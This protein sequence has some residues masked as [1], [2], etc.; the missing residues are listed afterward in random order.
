MKKILSI[1]GGGIKGVFP[2]SFLATL[3]EGLAHPIGE[4]FD[5]LVGTS[6][7]GIIALSLGLGKTAEQTVGSYRSLGAEV[8]GGSSFWRWIR[9]WSQAKYSSD[10]LKSNLIT[11]FGDQCLGHSKQRLL[12]PSLSLETGDVYIF[13][14]AHHR[15]Y[16]RDYKE[17][18]V[19]V[20]LATCAAPTFFPTFAHMSGMS[21]IDGGV[22]ANNPIN[23]A[24]TE[25]I[26]NLGWS[27][28]EIEVLSIG[29][30]QEALSIE[31]ARRQSKGLGYWGLKMTDLALHAQSSGSLG[32]AM[33]LLNNHSIYRFNPVVR[34]GKYQLDGVQ[35]MDFLQGLGVEEARKAVPALRH[36]FEETAEPYTPHYQLS[37][38][39]KQ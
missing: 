7:G 32:V 9:Q 26:G 15:R 5:L 21:L 8:F 12:I 34:G 17:T 10:A 31:S 24:V 3:E 29:C 4:Y 1:D 33:T 16:T 30:T 25:A 38:T 14:T 27:P 23:L 18:M 28:S 11:A 22:W 13:K 36:F 35:G 37:K 2:A 6:T 20:A 19:D 39:A